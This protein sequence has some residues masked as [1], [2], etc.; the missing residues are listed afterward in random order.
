MWERV[1][2][3]KWLTPKILAIV[4]ILSLL[5]FVFSASRALAATT[6][7]VKVGGEIMGAPLAKGGMIWF[8]GYDPASIV[9]HPGDT[10][11]WD[12]VGG[13]HTV[14]STALASNGSFLFDSSPLFTPAGAL[15]D[16]GPGMLLPP[17]SVY[18]LDTTGLALGKYTV[19]CKIHPGMQGNV[20]ITAGGPNRSIV[21]AM[22]GWGDHEYAVQAFS[23]ENLVVSSGTVIRWTLMN[24]TEPHTITGKNATNVVKWDSSPN[25]NPPGPPPVMIPNTP[26]ASFSYTFNTAGTFVYFCKVH[27][28]L[29]GQSWVGM[30]GIVHVVPLTSLD[31]VNAAVGGASAVGYGALGISIIALLVGVY[32]VVRGK[33]PTRSPPNP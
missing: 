4:S 12:A 16:M 29:I 3:S 5:V 11:T 31:A 15:A 10:I 7:H 6:Y 20:T 27:A 25:F 18:E 24:P 19:F 32:G 8:N 2:K 13:V 28:Y 23:P 33:G 30:M 1:R 26:S 22:A 14:T 17:G 21:T 9:I